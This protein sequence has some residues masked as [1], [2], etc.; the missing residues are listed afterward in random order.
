[1][2]TKF[3][4]NCFVL[5]LLIFFVFLNGCSSPRPIIYPNAYYKTVGKEQAEADI[6]IAMENA[7][8]FG[9]KPN[10]YGDEA[11]E[12]T[13]ST[14]VGAATGAATGAVIGRSASAAGTGAAAGAA[15]GAAA[16]STRIFFNWL[17]GSTKPSQAYRKFVEKQLKEKGYEIIGWE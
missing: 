5:V 4:K 7:K 1:M 10:L 15:G 13:T 17:F 14:A 16:G 3:L 9:L 2:E 8:K 12:A 11:A 6:D